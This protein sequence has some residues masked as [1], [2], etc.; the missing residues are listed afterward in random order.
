M[1][2]GISAVKSFR[3]GALALLL[4]GT[5]SLYASNPMKS[6]AKEP[7]H[8][9]T[10]VISKE[11]AEALKTRSLQGIN[12]ASVPTMHN[13]KLDNTLRKFISNK[14]DEE[15]INGMISEVYKNEGTFLASAYMQH[16]IN[17]Q[18]L[19]LLLDCKTDMLI[20][21]DINPKL[22]EKVK[23]IGPKFYNSI[24]K[25]GEDT[26]KWLENSYSNS[27]YSLLSFDHKPTGEEVIERIDYIAEK[28]A[29]FTVNELIDYYTFTKG[30]Q[31]NKINNKKDTQSL[32]DLIAY[33]MFML[34]KL[35]FLK[36]MLNG[37]IFGPEG[38]F[39]EYESLHDYYEPWMKS[40]EPK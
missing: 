37:G 25:Y 39:N 29:G 3:T 21:N 10:E 35:M 11:G 22:G 34:D 15:S 20:N 40:V 17:C 19:G 14:D 38:R 9:Y 2:K 18:Q 13:T 36:S 1:T 26:S 8:N 23:K 31:R 6:T 5:T 24:K 27:I 32:S 16:E 28:K 33:K 12:Q 30:F 4:A 7:Q